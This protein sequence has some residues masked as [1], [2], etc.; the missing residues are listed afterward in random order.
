MRATPMM[1]GDAGVPKAAPHPAAGI[2]SEIAG[3]MHR[4]RET[5]RNMDDDDAVAWS[6]L[7]DTICMAGALA[8]E[9]AGALGMNRVTDALDWV[10]SPTSVEAFKRLR[11]EGGAA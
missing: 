10:A 6:N 8:D 9:A 1:P 3:M 11:S 4:A 7:Q 5:M 2:F